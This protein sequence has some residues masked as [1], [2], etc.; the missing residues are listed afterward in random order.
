[1]DQI[2]RCT[3]TATLWNISGNPLVD[4]PL[5]VFK[6]VDAYPAEALD[7][8][9]QAHHHHGDG[10]VVLKRLTEPGSMTT[11][12]ID[13]QCLNLIVIDDLVAHRSKRCIHAI[14]NPSCCNRVFQ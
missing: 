14:D 9:I 7:Q 8:G 4:H 5:H 10:D 2:T 3:D 13:L 12:Q 11:D 6:Q 1:M